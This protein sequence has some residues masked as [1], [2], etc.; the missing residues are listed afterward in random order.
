LFYAASLQVNAQLPFEA[1]TNTSLPLLAS[2]GGFLVSPEPVT[3][4]ATQP[5]IFTT[6]PAGQGAILNVAY[7]LADAAAPVR[8][9]DVIQVYCTGLGATQPPAVSGA[10]TPGD[11]RYNAVTPV[12]AKVGGLDAI[13]QFSGL[14]PGYVGLYQVNLVV[15]AGVAAGN[16]VSL[17]LTQDGRDSNTVTF[18]VK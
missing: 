5:G 18:A 17:V 16:A 6:S 15:P 2:V 7:V 9:G 1:Q 3:I 13:V 8:S 14:A 12:T 4:A 10:A 11:A